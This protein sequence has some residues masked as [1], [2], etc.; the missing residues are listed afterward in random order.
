[1]ISA[2]DEIRLRVETARHLINVHI[3]NMSI[4]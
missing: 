3:S 4:S 2:E 1:M